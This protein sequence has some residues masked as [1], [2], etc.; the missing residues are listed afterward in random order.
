[1]STDERFETIYGS[2]YRSVGIGVTKYYDEQNDYSATD[3]YIKYLNE[4]GS[5]NENSVGM[6]ETDNCNSGLLLFQFIEYGIP[7]RHPC[8]NGAAVQF[9]LDLHKCYISSIFVSY[10]TF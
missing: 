3:Q 2:M 4:L 1:M 9:P 7:D 6:L 8:G 10:V 5:S